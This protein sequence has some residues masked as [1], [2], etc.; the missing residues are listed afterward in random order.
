M[1]GFVQRNPFASKAMWWKRYN[2]NQSMGKLTVYVAT[3]SLG[4]EI[5]LLTNTFKACQLV[6]GK[7]KTNDC[8]EYISIAETINNEL[9]ATKAIRWNNK[10]YMF[11]AASGTIEEEDL[12]EDGVEILQSNTAAITR[13]EKNLYVRIKKF[14]CTEES[15]QQD[16]SYQPISGLLAKSSYLTIKTTNFA[17]GTDAPATGDIITYDGSHWMISE[18]GK[19]FTYTPR[20]RQ[21]LHLSLKALK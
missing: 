4:F 18:V 1:K 19:T 13:F 6:N 20:K 3:P 15:D 5:D 8:V 17:I 21:T 7:L 14:N 2:S 9:K 16:S 10:L 12:A 11:N